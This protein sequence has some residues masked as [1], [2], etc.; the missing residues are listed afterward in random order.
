MVFI[1]Y[2]YLVSRTPHGWISQNNWKGAEEIKSTHV[3]GKQDLCDDGI[4]MLI[5]GS[6]L[7]LWELEG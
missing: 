1:C 6:C 7:S 2:L 5:K 3:N 4:H